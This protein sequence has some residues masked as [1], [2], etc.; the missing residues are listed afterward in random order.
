MKKLKKLRM[1]WIQW[2]DPC[3]LRDDW[4]KADYANIREGYICET[5]G[6]L[7]WEKPKTY[8]V[9]LCICDKTEY[10]DSTETMVIPKANVVKKRFL[11]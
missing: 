1:I 2:L 7:V 4:G 11:K 3:S 8:Y 9:A 6:F 5:V 10:Y